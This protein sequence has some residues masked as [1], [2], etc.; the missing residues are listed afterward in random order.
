RRLPAVERIGVMHHQELDLVWIEADVETDRRGEVAKQRWGG[1]CGDIGEGEG[2]LPAGD[3][4]QAVAE[5][6]ATGKLERQVV[7]VR[8]E[9]SELERDGHR[10][11]AGLPW[12]WGHDL[13]D[14]QPCLLRPGVVVERAGE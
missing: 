7:A 1:R 13:I 8:S 14:G 5:R 4:D 9:Q 3:H 12:R 10:L 6:R 2:L 11:L